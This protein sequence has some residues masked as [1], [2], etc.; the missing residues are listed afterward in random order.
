M[1]KK[2]AMQCSKLRYKQL[3]AFC[4]VYHMD[5]ILDSDKPT[6]AYR[7]NDF[8]FERILSEIQRANHHGTPCF[9]SFIGDHTYIK[10]RY[11]M[12]NGHL[13]LEG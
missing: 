7:E 8:D 9:G 2:V 6:I 10:V 13:K 3:G 4:R 1:G 11:L 5:S 12:H